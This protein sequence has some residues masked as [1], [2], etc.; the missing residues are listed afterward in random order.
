MAWHRAP[1]VTARCIVLYNQSKA[2]QVLQLQEVTEIG[3]HSLPIPDFKVP[4]H[5]QAPPRRQ[6]PPMANHSKITIV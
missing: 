2:A 5:V 1:P 4:N 6:A 3:H